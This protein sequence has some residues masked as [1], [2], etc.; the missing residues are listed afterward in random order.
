MTHET[1]LL[2][3]QG[4]KV[5]RNCM[6]QCSQILPRL[7]TMD[8]QLPS[9]EELPQEKDREQRSCSKRFDES[10]RMAASVSVFFRSLFALLFIRLTVLL[11][12]NES[13]ETSRHG[14]LIQRGRIPKSASHLS[15]YATSMFHGICPRLSFIECIASKGYRP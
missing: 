3:V 9:P 13:L 2:P 12:F 1:D 8:A 5:G 11:S 14:H 7:H 15:R 6:R 4:C 10:N